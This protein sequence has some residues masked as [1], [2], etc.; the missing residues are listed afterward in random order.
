MRSW[1]Q[2]MHEGTIPP[3]REYDGTSL[4]KKRGRLAQ[5]KRASKRARAQASN[6]SSDLKSERCSEAMNRRYLR[7]SASMGALQREGARAGYHEIMAS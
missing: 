2:D 6:K 7:Q 5:S 1:A 3:V 4:Q